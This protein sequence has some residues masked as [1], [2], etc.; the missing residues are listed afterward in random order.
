MQTRRQP[1]RLKA[2]PLNLQTNTFAAQC[3]ML[4][5]QRGTGG[6]D[7][8]IKNKIEK[9]C[10]VTFGNETGHKRPYQF[11]TEALGSVPL[12]TCRCHVSCHRLMSVRASSTVRFPLVKRKPL[13]VK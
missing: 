1:E 5:V 3:H 4:Q 7:T 9:K 11:D 10:N 13:V 8:I 2:F 12:Q 6:F